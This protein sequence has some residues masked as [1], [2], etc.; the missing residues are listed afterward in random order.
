MLSVYGALICLVASAQQPTRAQIDSLYGIWCDTTKAEYLREVILARVFAADTTLREEQAS[1]LARTGSMPGLSDKQRKRQLAMA[2]HARGIERSRSGQIDSALT[3]HDRAGELCAECGDRMGAVNAQCF[4]ADCYLQYGRYTE[5]V[6]TMQPAAQQYLLLGDTMLAMD[7]LWSIADALGQQGNSQGA[8]RIYKQALDL[9]GA[10][11][12]YRQSQF[13][14]GTAG[15]LV[16]AGELDTAIIV[17]DQAQRL[18]DINPTHDPAKDLD[19]MRAHVHLLQ[20]E[21]G[22][23]LSILEPLLAAVDPNG[24]MP[25]NTPYRF[26]YAAEAHLCIGHG[27]QAIRLAREGLRISEL[28]GLPVHRLENMRVL[29]DAYEQV[30]DIP[31][32]FM[33]S[34]RYHALKDSTYNAVAATAANNTVLAA[35]F[36]REQIADS[37]HVAVLHAQEQ[38]EARTVLERERTRRNIFLFAGLGLAVFGAVVFRQ[39]RRIQQALHRSDELL[40]NILPEEVAK[41]LKAKGE[42]DAQLIEHVTVLFTDFKGFTAM[43]EQLSPKALVK[44]IHECFSAFDHI[45]AKH[46]IEKIKTIGDAYMAAGGLPTPNNTH[47]HDVVNAAFE[48]RD[49]IAEGKALKIAKGLPYFEIRIGVHTGPVVAGIVGVKKFAYD[50]WGDTVNTASRMESSGEVGQVNISESTYALVKDET[51]L[52]FTSRGKV[53]AKGKGEMEMYFVEQRT[54]HC[55][56]RS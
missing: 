1:R 10:K 20:G 15:A 22:K 8:L 27:E 29:A 24:E 39:R 40:L 32:A 49:F 26:A 28:Y 11:Q 36:Q 41:E 43:S 23:A 18:L 12:P 2:F 16:T 44:D 42:A 52:A 35:E 21:C 7:A 51:G 34:K 6:R 56:H 45:M 25:P 3:W 54:A 19:V 33:M 4:M 46:G 5:A 48:I 9:L 31:K 14:L 47:A 50:I 55:E 13:L 37:V 38:A 53:Q 30:G 17:M